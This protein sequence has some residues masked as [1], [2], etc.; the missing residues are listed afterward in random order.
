MTEDRIDALERRVIELEAQN[1][2]L[3]RDMLD[4]AVSQTE[5]MDLVNRFVTITGLCFAV[6]IVVDVACLILEA[7][8]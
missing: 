1:R 5:V 7:F 2:M 6:L 3:R 8:L 4:W